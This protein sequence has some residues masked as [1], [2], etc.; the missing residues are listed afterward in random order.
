MPERPSTSVPFLDARLPSASCLLL[1]L[2]GRADLTECRRLHETTS[3]ATLIQ[4]FLD[5]AAEICLHLLICGPHDVSLRESNTTGLASDRTSHI[6]SS[7]GQEAIR[8]DTGEELPINDPASHSGLPP[9]WEEP[10]SSIFPCPGEN[11]LQARTI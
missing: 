1:L 6:S 3:S 5:P 9:P 7:S 11:T 2:R 10:P 4:S 8:L